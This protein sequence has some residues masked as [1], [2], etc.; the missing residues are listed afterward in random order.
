[1][2]H[3]VQQCNEFQMQSLSRR[4][5]SYKENIHS[6]LIQKEIPPSYLPKTECVERR[7]LYFLNKNKGTLPH[8]KCSVVIQI[9][10]CPA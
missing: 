3:Q 6:H 9:K 10:G 2:K 1:M 4:I 5:E 8:F 7:I